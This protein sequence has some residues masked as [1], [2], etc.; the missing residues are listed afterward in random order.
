MALCRNAAPSA[1]RPYRGHRYEC[2]EWPQVDVVILKQALP[3]GCRGSSHRDI[4]SRPKDSSKQITDLRRL[5]RQ[6]APPIEGQRGLLF[7]FEP[8]ASS[9]DEHAA[10]KAVK[11]RT[12]RCALDRVEGHPKERL[13]TD[14]IGLP[15][16]LP[17]CALLGRPRNTDLVLD[18]A[19]L[20]SPAANLPNRL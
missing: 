7:A 18:P 15:F 19:P 1:K 3:S 17:S 20:T 14:Q 13:W 8:F 6:T 2:L 11:M 10:L 12:H 9:D 5:L 4:A 16:L